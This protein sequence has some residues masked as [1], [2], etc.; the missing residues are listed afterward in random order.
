MDPLART[1]IVGASALPWIAEVI[2]QLRLQS[3]FLTALPEA[4]RAALPRH[5]RRP[6]LAFLGSTRFQVALWRQFRRDLPDDVPAVLTLKR[7]MRRSLWR[8]AA[9]VAGLVATGVVMLRA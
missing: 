2:V 1:L 3:R 9:W 6:W 8:E 7:R 5:P 4:A